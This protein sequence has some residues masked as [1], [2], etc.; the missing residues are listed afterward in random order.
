MEA[1]LQ[2]IS[3]PWRSGIPSRSH[4]CVNRDRF[5][6]TLPVLLGELA[7]GEHTS[8]WPPRVAPRLSLPL[9]H[10]LSRRLRPQPRQA[11]REQLLARKHR[12][13]RHPDPP[14]AHPHH[15]GHLQQQRPDRPEL[16]PRQL[17]PRQPALSQHLQQRR[18]EQG[19][20]Q[21]QLVRPP[22][23]RR[24]PVREQVQLLLLDAVLH[25]PAR[26]V[27]LL[28]QRL[29]PDPPP[30]QAGHH[31]ALVVPA[32]PARQPLRLDR[33]A[34]RRGDWAIRNPAIEPGGWYFE[35]A[36]EFYPDTDD[37]AKVLLAL[38]WASASDTQLQQEAETR[39]LK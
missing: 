37:T 23:R 8:R 34:K 18:R 7:Q 27:Q 11:V 16:R 1:G 22:R 26:A 31:Q 28:V 5:R 33:Q 3:R 9:A 38:E 2:L 14:P 12:G 17:R 15:R 21:P 30:L 24:S 6:G 20:V 13:Q 29:G 32:H 4:I 35:Y 36:N 39:A 19:P 25:V 10:R